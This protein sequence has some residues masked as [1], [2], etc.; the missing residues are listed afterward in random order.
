MKDRENL[1]VGTG[2]PWKDAANGRQSFAEAT[3]AQ[4]SNRRADDQVRNETMKTSHHLLRTLSTAAEAE[5]VPPPPSDAD[6]PKQYSARVMKLVDEIARMTLV[7]V[8]DLNAALK[9]RLNLPDMPAGMP[10]MMAPG[11]AAPAAQVHTPHFRAAIIPHYCRRSIKA[12]PM[13]QLP[14]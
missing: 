9:E 3:C 8:A 4:W 11:A 7:E 1:T 13:R 12:R 14:P 10:M 2:E 5:V 6:K